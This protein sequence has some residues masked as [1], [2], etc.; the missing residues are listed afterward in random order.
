MGAQQNIVARQ[1]IN[2]TMST[3]MGAVGMA[4]YY[5]GRHCMQLV[6]QRQGV[7]LQGKEGINSSASEELRARQELWPRWLMLRYQ[8]RDSEY[9]SVTEGATVCVLWF[10]GK[11]QCFREKCGHDRNYG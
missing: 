8:V 7:V 2:K 4:L 5:R 6:D 1:G 3:R 11:E 10:G 9:G